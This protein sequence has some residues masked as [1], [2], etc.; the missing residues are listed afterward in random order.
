MNRRTF[1]GIN[2]TALAV[3]AAYCGLFTFVDRVD[4][5]FQTSWINWKRSFGGRVVKFP[6]P[7]AADGYG[8]TD[9]EM[10]TAARRL[11]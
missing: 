1:T 11:F 6:S 3:S 10:L 7:A 8:G 2:T 9:K 4:I 5:R